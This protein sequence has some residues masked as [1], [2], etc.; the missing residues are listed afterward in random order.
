VEAVGYLSDDLQTQLKR[1]SLEYSM[2]D[3]VE[4]YPPSHRR[5]YVASA[6][7]FLSVGLLLH[8]QGCYFPEGLLL[9][10]LVLIVV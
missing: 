9:I 5:E 7:R 6:S 10:V 3:N 4:E 8:W 2:D 1:S